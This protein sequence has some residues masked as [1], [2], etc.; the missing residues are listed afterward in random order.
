MLMRVDNATCSSEMR[1]CIHPTS[2]IL[3]LLDFNS[4]SSRPVK[5]HDDSTRRSDWRRR[6]SPNHPP[7]SPFDTAEHCAQKFHI[8][9]STT[10]PSEVWSH[11]SVDVVFI[12][13]SDEFHEPYTVASLAAGKH[14]FVEKPLTLSL[15]SAHRILAAEAAAN[16]PR[17]FVGYM[18]RYAPSFTQTLRRELAGVGTILYARV[19]DFSGPNAKFV[20]ESGTFPARFG[21]DIPAAATRARDERV[22]TLLGEV[23]GD[24]RRE[25]SA[26]GKAFVRFLG[27]L[28]SHDL[29]LMREVLGLPEAVVGV[30]VNDPFYSA[31]LRYRSR[32]G[33]GKGEEFSVTYESGVDEVPDFDAHFAVYG[34]RKRV[35]IKYDS[36]FVKG[37]AIKVTVQEVNESGEMESREMLGSYEDAYTVELKELYAC[38][39]EGK[40]IKTSAKDAAED[41]KVVEMMY[42]C[43]QKQEGTA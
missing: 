31:I 29:S 3:R 10:S 23:V 21:D 26:R 41:L 37:L 25:M 27:T 28:G 18:R 17:V 22:A 11:P 38:L 9:H 40:E 8:P 32:E 33:D 5:Q 16:G 39:V 35:M 15:A 2:A 7:P 19:R 13:T 1:S 12:L 36:P 20:R 42:Q 4:S 14:V 43:W 34:R 24:G 6:G 30:S